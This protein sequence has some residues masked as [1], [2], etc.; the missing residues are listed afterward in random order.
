ML[1]YL[2]VVNAWK[3]LTPA[4]GRPTPGGNHANVTSPGIRSSRQM[5]TSRAAPTQVA[6]NKPAFT[7]RLVAEEISW[8]GRLTR[9]L[10]IG[11]SHIVVLDEYG[12]QAARWDLASI[13][14]A[15][16]TRDVLH[17]RVP[18]MTTCGLFSRTVVFALKLGHAE[19]SRLASSIRDAC[20]RPAALRI[21]PPRRLARQP[22]HQS[23]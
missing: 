12:R 11:Q 1:L 8:R 20:T 21:H 2:F 16:G 13:V 5:H 14:D 15:F 9:T 19:C 18:C 7:Q 23:G 4:N 22:C 10:L 3:L 6:G 17:L